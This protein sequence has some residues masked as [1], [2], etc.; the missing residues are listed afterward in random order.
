[1]TTWSICSGEAGR[2]TASRIAT[3]PR[4]DRRGAAQRRPELADRSPD[5]GDDNGTVHRRILG[6]SVR[7]ALSGPR[8]RGAGRWIRTVGHRRRAVRA[9]DGGACARAR[10]RHRILGRPMGFWRE[11]MPQ[12]M[13]LRSGADWHLDAAGVHTL[14]AYLEERRSTRGRRP[15]PDRLFLDYAEWFTQRKEIDVREDSSAA[16]TSATAGSRRRSRAAS[17]SSPTRWSLL[18]ASAITRPS[19][20]GQSRLP[21][22]R[23]AH[24]CDLVDFGDIAGARVLIVGGR[25]SAYEWAALIREH[26]AARIDI[27]HRHDVP[28]FER[29]SWRFVDAHVERTISVPGYWRKLAGERAGSDHTALLGGRQADARTLADS[30]A[31]MG[32]HP[33][34]ARHRG[35][36]GRSHRHRRSCGWRSRTRAAHGRPCRLRL[37]IPRRPGAVPYLETV[38]GRARD[39]FPVLDE[40][41][42]ALAGLYITG[43]SATTTS[44]RSSA[45]S[46]DP[47]PPRRSSF[48][49]SCRA[50]DGTDRRPDDPR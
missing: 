19:Q 45:S 30:A 9:F 48:A 3:A 21:P 12:G 17:R 1:M 23:S 16:S 50:T 40:F 29:V 5:C 7:S 6:S 22:G 13:F 35:R 33:Q 24:T 41:F 18:P 34:L 28:R 20:S 32:G 46:K 43:F 38:D 31:R 11:N 15:D 8:T 47:R 14:E 25:Q 39:G 49:T 27:V 36:R 37:R 26:G 2:A 44:G 10:H 42:A 4:S